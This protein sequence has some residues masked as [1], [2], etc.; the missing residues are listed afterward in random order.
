MQNNKLIY[1]LIISCTILVSCISKRK[2]EVAYF[3]NGI[4]NGW[5][6]QNSIVIWT[7][8]TK[9]PEL[10]LGGHKFIKIDH[11][12]YRKYPVT[13]QDEVFH[14]AQIPDSLSLE[15]MEGA[16]PGVKG[17]VKIKYYPFENSEKSTE[18]DWKPVDTNKNFTK[19]WKLENLLAGT[20]YKV[21]LL[22]RSDASSAISDTL[23]GFFQLPAP[24]DSIVNASFCIVTG[25]DFNRRDDLANGHK[26]YKE[27]LELQPDFYAHTGDI[28]YYDKPNPCTY[29]RTNAF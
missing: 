13:T 14:K 19:Q 17:E 18:I 1:F 9:T 3:G 27:M 23:T 24:A 7:R 10:K 21:E 5:A 8:L 12:S 2:I 4:R 6:D 11:A 29:R 22:A 26:I 16:C 15:Q 25:H 20:K 28:E